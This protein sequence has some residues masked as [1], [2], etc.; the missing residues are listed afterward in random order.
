MGFTVWILLLIFLQKS[1]ARAPQW[2][3]FP[4]LSSLPL[5]A[6]FF[7]E[8]PPA[9]EA[10]KKEDS[11]PGKLAWIFMALLAALALFNLAEGRLYDEDHR[12]MEKQLEADLTRLN[13]QDDQLFIVWG[14]TFPY[15]IP[16]AFD[17]FESFRHFHIFSLSGLQRS[18]LSQVQLER[19]HLMNPFRE[20]VDNPHCFLICSPIQGMLYVKYM[21]ERFNLKIRAVKRFKSPFFSVYRIC[22]L[23]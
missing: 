22:S 7:T 8:P 4:E 6:L 15:E 3:F 18:P 5:L 10:K 1:F 11:N 20:M 12:G 13:P 19:F 23:D 17:S 16:G 21:K 2:V 14:S 9:Q